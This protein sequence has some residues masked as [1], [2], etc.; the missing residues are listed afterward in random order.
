MLMFLIFM[1][2]WIAPVF[3]LMLAEIYPLRMRGLGMGLS[4]FGLW[5]FDFIIQSGFPI[6]LNHYGGGM[7]FGVFAGTNLIMLMLLVKYLPETRGLTLEQI[8]QKFRF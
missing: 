3:W 1:Q 4:V 5:I 7:T 6:L 2:G 8:E